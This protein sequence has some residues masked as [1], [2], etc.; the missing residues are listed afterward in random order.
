LYNPPHR[1]LSSVFPPPL[2]QGLGTQFFSVKALFDPPPTFPVPVWF[3]PLGAS[4]CIFFKNCF[5]FIPNF[6]VGFV[7]P[8]G[9]SLETRPISPPDLVPH[10]LVPVP[11]SL[12]FRLVVHNNLPACAEVSSFLLQSFPPPATTPDNPLP[13][14]AGPP[15]RTVSCLIKCP[16]PLPVFFFPGRPFFQTTFFFCSEAPRLVGAF[17]PPAHFTR[18]TCQTFSHFA[19]FVRCLFLLLFFF[20][21][22]DFCFIPDPDSFPD[23]PPP[24]APSSFSTCPHFY[25]CWTPPGFSPS[26]WFRFL[27]FLFVWLQSTLAVCIDASCLLFFVHALELAPSFIHRPPPPAPAIT[28]RFRHISF[29]LA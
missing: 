23:L 27:L 3:S 17:P 9:L 25:L 26:G 21:S 2:F 14:P 24:N 20:V 4:P 12:S 29:F 1:H 11:V 18:P 16:C 7:A 6:L 5:W 22:S 13:V 28:S 8:Y 19:F 15:S 10:N